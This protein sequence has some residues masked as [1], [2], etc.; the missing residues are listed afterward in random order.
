MRGRLL[1][2]LGAGGGPHQHPSLP[3]FLPIIDAVNVNKTVFSSTLTTLNS[4]F[5]IDFILY[6]FGYYSVHC[7]YLKLSPGSLSLTTSGTQ[8]GQIL[9]LFGPLCSF[10]NV[11]VNKQLLLKL[12]IVNK[13]E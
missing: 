5:L 11:Y 1:R 12:D 2:R 7:K 9:S 4:L 13:V 8:S 3:L 10:L 6:I